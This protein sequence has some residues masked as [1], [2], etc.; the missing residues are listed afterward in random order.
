MF[1]QCFYD[2]EQNSPVTHTS[3]MTGSVTACD[4]YDICQAA[5]ILW[6]HFVLCH[7]QLSC[8]RSARRAPYTIFIPLQHIMGN[9]GI[10]GWLK[11]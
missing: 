2:D 9:R 4:H 8:C 6:Q 1:S 7:W 3:C 5:D 11:K 10:T